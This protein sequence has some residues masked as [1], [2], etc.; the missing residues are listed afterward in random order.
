M[1]KV[2]I[3]AAL[4]FAVV[5]EGEVLIKNGDRIAFLGDSITAYGNKMQSGYVNMVM[6]GLK[7]N[8]IEA[9]KI[10]AG[11]SGNKSNQMLAR[12]EKDILDHKPQVL[13]VS[14][15][16]NDVWHGARGVKLEEY[17]KNIHNIIQA[18][19]AQGI[20]V[21][22]MTSTMIGEQE[23]Y[24]NNRK[25]D[26]YN[27]VLRE[28]AKL[29]NC[30][31]IDTGAE[32]R[33]M[34]RV[35]RKKYPAARGP[36]LTNDNVHMNPLGDAMLARTIL[37]AWGMDADAVQKADLSWRKLKFKSGMF[38]I[39]YEHFIYLAEF[40]GQNGITLDEALEKVVNQH[41]GNLK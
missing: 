24:P 9:V 27:T 11:I 34:V 36:Y 4:I 12:L 32:M 29:E 39:S 37:K 15:G 23:N 10:P 31:L 26:Q 25:L 19:K 33:R 28:L 5:A 18:A 40:A 35:Y 14:C 21:C 16:V 20:T 17:R 1:K 2:I 3:L 38:N 8:G 7:V 41:I 22:L 30:L 6:Q 13:L